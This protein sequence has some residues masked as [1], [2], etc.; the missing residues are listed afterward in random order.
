MAAMEE[1]MAGAA[2]EAA[3]TTAGEPSELPYG[4]DISAA[5]KSN[6]KLVPIKHKS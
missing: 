1:E 6:A 4:G 2:G 5:M 3:A